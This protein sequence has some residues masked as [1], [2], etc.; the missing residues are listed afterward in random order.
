MLRLELS[1]YLSGPSVRS[2]AMVNIVAMFTLI[3]PA[4]RRNNG[5]ARTAD[6]GNVS[7]N[8]STTSCDVI[9]STFPIAPRKRIGFRPMLD[10][11]KNELGI[12]VHLLLHDVLIR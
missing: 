1:A 2:D 11:K 4:R 9:E 8:A 12:S 3:P 6:V 5:P 7:G 10:R